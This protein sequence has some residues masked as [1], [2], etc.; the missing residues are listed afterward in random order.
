PLLIAIE[1]TELTAAALRGPVVEPADRRRRAARLAG[2]LAGA[3]LRACGVD[4][5]LAPVLD[6]QRAAG[7]GAI[8]DRAWHAEP[9]RAALLAEAWVEGA[10]RAGV[11]AV[12][13]HF[14]GHGS[15]AEDSHVA[16]PHDSRPLEAIIQTDLLPFRRLVASGVPALMA[17]HVVYPQADDR[18][19]GYSRYWLERVLRRELGFRGAVLSDD[20]GMAAAGAAGGIGERVEACL[21]AGCDA[22]LV[23]RPGLVGEALDASVPAGAP[24]SARRLARL[25]GEAAPGWEELR[26]TRA[27]RSAAAELAELVPSG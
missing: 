25:R 22:A 17:A 11:A 12:A 9:E 16:L 7:G 19:A 15:V 21:A 1:G 5:D 2:W 10:R 13:K 14:P 26:A 24:A 20:L 4:L 3:E 8:G 18:P 6:L 27:W 23:C